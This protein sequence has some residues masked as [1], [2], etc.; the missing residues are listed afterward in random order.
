MEPTDLVVVGILGIALLRG[1][2]RG[3]LREV[4][5]IVALA[6]ACVFYLCCRC[7]TGRAPRIWIASFLLIS[8]LVAIVAYVL[9]SE[10]A[11]GYTALAIVGIAM[12]LRT[13][14]SRSNVQRLST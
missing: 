5:S 4:F 9:R 8:V 3:L 13:P 14:R 6:G 11:I 12:T 1:F 7:W 10:L 2:F